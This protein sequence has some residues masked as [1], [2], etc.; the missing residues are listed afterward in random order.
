MCLKAAH[1]AKAMSCCQWGYYLRAYS[2]ISAITIM[3]ALSVGHFGQNLS[4]KE[5]LQSNCNV[6]NA[7]NGHSHYHCHRV[8]IRME[9]IKAV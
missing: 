9:P 1:Q 5:I 8:N 2:G 6:Y 7:C 4:P 3:L